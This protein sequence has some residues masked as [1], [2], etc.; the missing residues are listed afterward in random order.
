MAIS[1]SMLKKADWMPAAWTSLKRPAFLRA[2][3]GVRSIFEAQHITSRI[4]GICSCGHTLASIQAAEDALG[5]TPTAQTI[6]LRKLLLHFEMLDS[7]I[8]HIYLLVAPD[9]LGVKSVIPLIESH[10][11]Y[12][13]TYVRG[14]TS[15]ELKS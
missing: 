3:K 2:F 7:H 11:K 1:S 5:I 4:C 8:L 10:R 15:V 14:F 6:K 9:L 12:P 13:R